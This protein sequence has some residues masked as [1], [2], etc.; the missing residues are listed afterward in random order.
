M[1]R[2][3][4]FLDLDVLIR[5]FILSGAFEELEKHCEVTYV[6]H[7]DTTSDKKGIYADVSKLNL[8]RVVHFEIPRKRMGSW[9]KLYQITA[10][11]N[12]RGTTHYKQRRWQIANVRGWKRTRYYELLS[13]PGIFPFARKRLLER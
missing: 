11:H 3:F 10:L 9:D 13:F 5:H 12:Q 2:V 8:K 7:T 1:K 4:V 6:I